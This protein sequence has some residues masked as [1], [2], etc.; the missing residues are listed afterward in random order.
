[1]Q[2]AYLSEPDGEMM[3]RLF[4]RALVACI[5]DGRP[6]SAGELATMTRRVWREVY[7]AAGNDGDCRRAKAVARLALSGTES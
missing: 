6:P 2:P 1:M 7:G 3:M 5:A 4:P